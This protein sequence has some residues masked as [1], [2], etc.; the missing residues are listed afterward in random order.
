M[1]IHALPI[2]HAHGLFVAIHGALIN[3]SKIIWMAKFDARAVIAAMSRATV[4]M[5]VPTLYVRMLAEPTLTRGG[6]P[7]A[8]VHLRLPRRC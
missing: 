5:G 2:F 4:F 3:G 8:A 7:D 1:L 6:Q